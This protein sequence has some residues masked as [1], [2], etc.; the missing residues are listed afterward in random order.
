MNLHM[1]LSKKKK[2]RQI[3]LWKAVIKNPI[4]NKKVEKKLR[5]IC[6]RIEQEKNSKKL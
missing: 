3:L 5:K 2:N 4:S 1:H 6:R